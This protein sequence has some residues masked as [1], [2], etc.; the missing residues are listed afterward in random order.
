MIVRILIL[1]VRGLQF[2]DVAKKGLEFGDE[3]R[4]ILPWLICFLSLVIAAETPEE[5]KELE[6]ELKEQFQPLIDYMKNETK[7]SLQ[8]GI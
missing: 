1:A 6:K 3:G 2:Q 5:E 7:S 8:D 4:N